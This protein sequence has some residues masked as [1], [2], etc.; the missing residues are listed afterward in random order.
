MRLTPHSARRSSMKS[1]TV[2]DMALL[3]LFRSGVGNGGKQGVRRLTRVEPRV[4]DDD[5]D[6]GADHARVVGVGRKPLGIRKLVEAQVPGAAWRNLDPVGASRIT[7]L[8]V[9]G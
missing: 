9:H 4:L 6:V 7:I 8:E 1:A 5:R 2:F 3:L